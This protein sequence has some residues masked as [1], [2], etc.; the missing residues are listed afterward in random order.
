[1]SRV[2]QHLLDDLG[3][4][5]KLAEKYKFKMQVVGKYEQCT[6][7][8]AN[9]I[10]NIHSTPL[11]STP[12]HS[13]PLH[14]TPLHST[15]LHSTPLHSTPLHSTPLHSTLHCTPLFS[16]TVYHWES[17]AFNCIFKEVYLLMLYIFL[18]GLSKLNCSLFL[19]N[20]PVS[21]QVMNWP[22]NYQSYCVHKLVELVFSKSLEWVSWPLQQPEHELRLFLW[23]TPEAVTSPQRYIV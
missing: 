17:V 3:K 16:A 12:L 8:R 18:K 5:V 19:T 23:T 11:H 2:K 13:T 21:L 7:N 15:P 20:K 6:V 9:P 1:M 14:S 22:C 4:L 10:K